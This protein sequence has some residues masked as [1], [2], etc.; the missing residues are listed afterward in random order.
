[1]NALS[2]SDIWR[3]GRFLWLARFGWLLIFLLVAGMYAANLPHVYPDTFFEWRVGQAFPAALRFFPSR[4]AFVQ[5]VILLR[6]VTAAIFVGTALFLAWRRSNDWFVL[7]VSAA[8]LLLSILFGT[9]FD[10]SIIRYP[11]G[12]GQSF[13]AIRVIAPSLLLISMIL[14]F[15]LFPD[16]RFT[17]RWTAWLVLPATILILLFFVVA[18]F[19]PGPWPVDTSLAD[20]VGWGIFV[21]TLFGTAFAGLVSQIIRYRRSSS[22]K[23]R[24]QTKWALLGLSSLILGPFFDWVILDLFLGRW[25]GYSLRHFV[26]LYLSILIPIFLPLTIAFSILRYRLWD[27]D[28]VIN[29]ALVYGMLTAVILALYGLSV[30]LA[31]VLVPAQNNQP[32]SILALVTVVFLVVQ[33]R[34]RLQ[35]IAD[36]WLPVSPQPML[37]DE[38]MGRRGQGTPALRLA[39]AA[40]LLL[41]AFLLWQM[42]AHFTAVGDILAAIQSEWLVQTSRPALPDISAAAFA[43]YVL[44]MRLAVL[45]LF[46]GT[47]VL[48][49]HRQ[50]HDKMALF[51]AFFLLLAPA[52]FALSGDENWLEEGLFVP[53]IGLMVL[54]PFLFPDGR[55][56]PQSARW[57]GLLLAAVLAAPFLAYPLVSLFRPASQPDERAY[58]SF[59]VAIVVAMTAGL[60]SQVYRYRMV[61]TTMQRQQM[62][63]VLL[64]LGAV[65]LWLFWGVLWLV[66]VLARLGVSEPLI[67]LVTLHLSI[68]GLAALPVTIAL[69]ILRYRLWDIDLL[70]NRTLVFGGLTLLVAAAYI[71]VVGLLGVLFQA[72]NNVFLSILATG[73]IAILFHPLRQ[74]L[75]QIVNRLTYGERD[76]PV[77][78]LSRLGEQL[79]NTAVPEATLPALVETVAQA[80]KLPYAAIAVARTGD[81]KLR[82]EIVAVYGHPPDRTTAFALVYQGEHIGQLLV[83]PR[84][85][86]ESFTPAEMRLLENI[87]RQTGAAVY[88]YQLTHQLQHSRE[89]LVTT[90]EEERRRLRRDLHDGLGPQLATLALKVDAARN[91][92]H[93]KPDSARPESIEAADHL[94]IEL[95]GQIQAAIQDV[96]R[97]AY[98]LRP[99]A[100]DQLGLA[101]ALSEYAAQNSVNGLLITVEAAETLPPLSAAVEVAAYR[102]ALEAMTNVMRHARAA[103]CTVR[104]SLYDGQLGLEISDNGLGMPVPPPPGV[105]LASMRER[106][107]ELGGVFD[108]QSI[109]GKGVKVSV[110]LP[111]TRYEQ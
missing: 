45:A 88:A 23:Q 72:A 7:F 28:L 48:I 37:L 89:R 63:W 6:L 12:L 36:R 39:R 19:F 32:L 79:E 93:H 42:T 98:E 11:A 14:L 95:K 87:A 104:L 94:L 18:I 15:Y 90:R 75:Q 8:L 77:S 86:G 16:G 5:S 99:P 106:A 81:G 51:V 55:F 73:L 44:V 24:Q 92:L 65:F 17:P 85:P 38:P 96:R 69:S 10:V 56:I 29:R 35:T 66:G 31:S 2:T 40:W 46:W 105:G 111:L 61:A 50:R 100:L 101:P 25:V 110:R 68:L 41:F 53:A 22:L 3:R 20:E 4:M 62:K 80:L 60:A 43:R 54:L 83:A 102:I 21:Y 9:N 1:M 30:G 49:F 84:A 67:A 76:D 13:P 34:P 109:P 71:L 57:R 91:Y 97:L 78:V 103:A 47:A 107:A 26:S 58:G 59:I 70:I 64:G 52:S 108:L 33:L 27:V 74:R 82:D